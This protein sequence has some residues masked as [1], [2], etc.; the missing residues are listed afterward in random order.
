MKV[1]IAGAGDVGFYLAKMLSHESIDIT[2]ID[3]D[4]E[5]LKNVET[6][7][8]V[9]TMEGSSTSLRCLRE[10]KIEE[11]DLLI[12]VTDS[13]DVNMTT[14]I[15]GKQLGARRTIARMNNHEFFEEKDKF[16]FRKL[17]LDNMIFPEELAAKEIKRLIKRASFSES[18]DF[19]DG[20]L[21]FSGI[22]LHP[23][24]PVIH[25]SVQESAWLNPEL[26]FMLVAIKRGTETIIP[27]GS[28]MFMPDDHLYFISH[29]EGVKHI[30]SISGREEVEVR[31]I[32]ILGG[33]KIGKMTAKRLQ[34]KYRVKLIEIDREKC[35]EISAEL[36][37][38]LVIHG[39]GRDVT[40]LEEENISGMDALIAVTGNSETNIIT[41][42]VAKK[43][44][45][46]KTVSLVE[47]VELLNLSQDIG[48]DALINKKLI[49]ASYIF[50]YIREGDV[51][52][53]TNIHGMDAEVLEFIVKPRS[54]I[55]N[56]IIKEVKFP[57][58]AIIGGVVRGAESYIPMGDFRIE[59]RDRVVV[60]TLPECIHKVE[61]FFK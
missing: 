5:K 28:S 10:A 58:N 57:K 27:R 15:L 39:D 42:L 30:I 34:D 50:R 8:D 55:T 17:G 20:K 46:K 54:K 43:H 2:V 41:G 49:A 26:N 52:A 38:T 16:D 25:K 44:G 53:L 29:P 13:E 60:F 35:D 1:V 19:A 18:F 7:F 36:E 6:H 47:N 21:T 3:I 12:A 4:E 61:E 9:L 33:G 45:V 48:I 14:A 32:M 51:N 56:K 22:K 23:S 11:A 31:D 24:S 40:L 59:Q 37:K